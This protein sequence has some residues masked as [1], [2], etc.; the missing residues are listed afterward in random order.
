[1]KED[2]IVEK[3]YNIASEFTDDDLLL[4]IHELINWYAER[5][6]QNIYKEI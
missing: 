5:M 4:I 2:Y 3:A 6:K 1:M